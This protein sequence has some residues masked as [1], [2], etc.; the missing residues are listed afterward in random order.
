MKI[1]VICEKESPYIVEALLK[2]LHRYNSDSTVHVFSNSDCFLSLDNDEKKLFLGNFSDEHF[3]F[4]IPWNRLSE[5]TGFYFEILKHLEQKNRALLNNSMTF[6]NCKNR[7]HILQKLSL[8]NDIKIPK[9]LLI[10]DKSKLKKTIGQLSEYPVVLKTLTP[11]NK[12]L[13]SVFITELKQ[14]ELFLD[15]NYMFSHILKRDKSIVIQEYL[16]KKADQTFHCLILGGQVI[17]S[18]GLNQYLFNS[19]GYAPL[20]TNPFKN[21]QLEE[22][23]EKEILNIASLFNLNFG[24]ISFFDTENDRYY[25]NINPLPDIEKMELDYDTPIIARLINSI[26]S[27]CR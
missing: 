8:I 15:L 25:Y 13:D 16:E 5:G 1:A 4:F 9:S 24:L 6:L 27:T 22:K 11:I 10:N 14:A 12:G 26:C 23:E 20:K 21:I 3:D 18:Y 17:F 7:Y 19:M 2:A